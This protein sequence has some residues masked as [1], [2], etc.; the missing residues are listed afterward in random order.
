MSKSKS[1]F[2][3][4]IYANLLAFLILAYVIIIS[5]FIIKPY[6][7]F[8]NWLGIFILVSFLI[9]GLILAIESLY[10]KTQDFRLQT[11]ETKLAV[12]IAAHNAENTIANTIKSTKKALPNSKI[13]VVNDGSSDATKK[14]A[15]KL[16]VEVISL[17]Q[18]LGK[19][20]AI[21]YALMRVKQPYILLLDDDTEIN[22]AI[23]PTNLLRSYDAVAFN[24][25]PFGQS[26]FHQF[27]RHEYR[28]SAS[29]GKKF[30]SATA[31][32]S[33]ISGACGLFRRDVLVK[34]IKKHSGHFSG[35]DLQRTLLIHLGQKPRGV[36]LVDQI[37]Y[38]HA[39][40]NI[41]ELYQQRVYGWWPGLWNNIN[42]FI[43]LA[44]ARRTPSKLRF[45]AFYSLFMIATDILRLISLP[46]LF[47][48]FLLLIPFWL[49]YSLLEIIPYLKMKRQENILVVLLAPLYGIFNLIT[50]I[51]GFFVWLYRRLLGL[52]HKHLADPHTCANIFQRFVASTFGILIFSLM[53]FMG[54]LSTE[55]KVSNEVLAEYNRRTNYC[56]IEE[57]PTYAQSAS[58]TSSANA[59]KHKEYV[60][61]AQSGDGLSLIARKAI[62]AYR[63]D[64]GGANDATARLEAEIAIT[65]DL[66][67]N[68]RHVEIGDCF[69]FSQE[70]LASL[71]Q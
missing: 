58:N 62:A 45:E 17:E 46:L 22:G 63:N 24:V 55:S 5:C 12:L 39:P 36:V 28:K 2:I 42:H 65:K 47:S 49:F 25:L 64:F 4:K 41:L 1:K 8:L 3:D 30:H 33:C 71:L 54:V 7:S 68:Y 50:R 57:S 19:V 43:C 10:S 69:S 51:I 70:Y 67:N 56:T 26:L 37:V 29:I 35:E 38:T 13:I 32:V 9:D 18:N 34:Q 20:S 60:I 61:N 52:S 66:Q 53:I 14:I 59:S 44:F 11:D 16:G 6:G 40:K 31:S 15:Q 21:N 48:S 27:Q 23:I